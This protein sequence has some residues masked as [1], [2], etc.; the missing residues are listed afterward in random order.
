[1]ADR[2]LIQLWAQTTGDGAAQIDIPED[3][4]IVG[5]D[6]DMAASDLD[7]VADSALAQ[8]S[9][10]STNQFSVNDARG[11]ISS[12]S[13]RANNTEGTATNPIVSSVQKFVN[14][15]NP[16]LSV[17]GGERLHLHLS[18]STGV[19]VSVRCVVH[20]SVRGTAVRRSRRRR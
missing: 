15:E 7:S 12:I 16:G 11:V 19:A 1:M 9:F 20:L 10:L 4:L 3:A 17:A 13:I 6:W 2:T 5:V 14:M 18:L 8:L